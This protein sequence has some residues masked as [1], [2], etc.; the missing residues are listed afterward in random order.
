MTEPNLE[1][2]SHSK[3]TFEAL[4][5]EKRMARESIYRSRQVPL[6]L[7]YPKVRTLNLTIRR[8]S[9][10]DDSE[11]NIEKTIKEWDEFFYKEEKILK[12][13]PIKD[14][15]IHIEFETEKAKYTLLSGSLLAQKFFDLLFLKD[16]SSLYDWYY[17]D[18]DHVIDDAHTGMLFFI[19]DG[20]KI[21]N[22]HVFISE[23]FSCDGPLSQY[24][25][26]CS[27][28][29]AFWH[30]DYAS[31][32]AQAKMMYDKYFKETRT[33]A[34]RKFQEYQGRHYLFPEHQII[35]IADRILSVVNSKLSI[36]QWAIVAL[37]LILLFKN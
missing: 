14:T 5:I 28:E 20:D 23:E 26:P 2:D 31:R 24:I 27:D 25:Y 22:E 30:S 32:L 11:Q 29:P 6:R 15:G 10:V 17:L 16:Y 34:H 13:V 12:P 8:K 36:I 3:E 7:D 9:K 21:V 19:A 33:G 35:E 1:V 4:T 18:S 37:I